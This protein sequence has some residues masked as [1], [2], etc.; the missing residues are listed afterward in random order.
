[1]GNTLIFEIGHTGHLLEYIHHI[2]LSALRKK[3][4]CF[5][6]VVSPKLK[7]LMENLE[8]EECD[9]IHFVF[10]NDDDVERCSKGRLLVQSWNSSCL[11]YKYIKKYSIDNVLLLYLMK[12]MPILLFILPGRVNVS[13]IV[14]RIFLYDDSAKK[15][16]LRKK[17]EWI[18]YWMMANARQISK[19]LILNDD[20]SVG[21]FNKMFRTNKFQR[22][23]DPCASIKSVPHSIRKELGISEDSLM[24][25]LFG[26]LTERKGVLKIL[27]AVSMIEENKNRYSF[28]FAGKIEKRIKCEVHTRVEQLK[29]DGY[30]ID[31]KDEFCSYDFLNSLCYSCD[32]VLIPYSNT[33]QSSGLIGYA[34]QFKKT[35]IGPSDGLLGNLIKQYSLGY[36]IP[37]ITAK[38][39]YDAIVNFRPMKLSDEYV[40]NNQVENFI[41]TVLDWS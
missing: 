22:L 2:Y 10:L 37:T 1:M 27:D 12:Y 29:A 36:S 38:N 23:A 19:I 6:F 13:G 32:S 25:I 8:W 33:C 26:N 39:I 31:L 16:W 30:N 4:E 15:S 5:Y 3:D 35:V 11:L 34:A 14:Y 7:L 28:Y 41:E 40:K 20:Y 21:V 17:I 18:R 24:F 9:R